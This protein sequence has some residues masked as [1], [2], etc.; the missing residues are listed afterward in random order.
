MT[1]DVSTLSIKVE[2]SNIKSTATLLDKLGDVAEKTEKRVDK[3]TS[4]FDKLSQSFTNGRGS[5]VAY[6][7]ALG[8]S[9]SSLSELSKSITEASKA[10]NLLV[11]EV[12]KVKDVNITLRE[13]NYAAGN[14]WKYH[15]HWMW[16]AMNTLQA[17]TTAF[18]IYQSVNIAKSVI[19]QADAWGQMHARLEAATG[20]SQNATAAQERMFDVSQKLRVPLEDSVRLF[21]RLY[22]AMQKYGKTGEDVTKTVEQLGMGLKLSGATGAEAASV[23]LQLSQSASSGVINGAEFNAVAENGGLIMRALEQYTGKTTAQLKKMGSEGKLSFETLTKSLDAASPKWQ[24]QFDRMPITFEDGMIRIQNAWTYAMGQ[25]GKD[26]EFN[27]EISQ[28]LRVIEKM[29]PAVAKG[30]GEAFIKISKWLDRNKDTLAEI[31]DQIKGVGSDIVGVVEWIAEWGKRI[32]GVTKDFNIFAF[33]LYS[34]RMAVAGIQDGFDAIAGTVLLVGGYITKYILS[35]IVKVAV[36]L[37][38]QVYTGWTSLFSLAAKGADALGMKGVAEGLRS[39]Q[40]GAEGVKSVLDAIKQGAGET[41]DALIDMGKGALT[42]LANASKVQ[43]LLNEGPP[44]AVTQKRGPG[45]FDDVSTGAR[46]PTVDEKALAA[47]KKAQ[48]DWLERLRKISDALA[49]QNELERS[50]LEYGADYQKLTDTQKAR[51]K[52]ERELQDARR[53]GA[54]TTA[55]QLETELIYISLLEKRE[56]DTKLL[57]DQAKDYQSIVDGLDSEADRV[58]KE[59]AEW[60]R[61]AE[62]VKGTKGAVAELTAEFYNQKAAEAMSEGLEEIANKYLR[63]AAAKQ[64][65]SNSQAIIGEAEAIERFNKLLEAS[66]VDKFGESLKDAF[67]AAGKALGGMADALRNYAVRQ[68]QVAK[69]QKELLSIKDPVAYNKAF[70]EMTE[71]Q[72]RGQIESYAE[73]A[74]GAKQFFNERSKEY[75]T[76]EA[77]EKAYRLFELAMSAKTFAQKIGLMTAETSATVANN[78]VK[79]SSN[80][81]TALTGAL[82]AGW[83]TGI[84]AYATVAAMLAAIGVAVSGGGG[85]KS[86]EEM[87]ASQNTGTVLGDSS[88]KSES[89]A[90][91]IDNLSDNSDVALKY[92]ANMLASL[93]NIEQA[94]T[95]VST[96]LYS[97][98][99]SSTAGMTSSSGV[100]S[101]GD[102]FSSGNIANSL[103]SGGLSLL[104]GLFG[105]KTSVKDY[106]IAA[107]SQSLADILENGFQGSTY[108]TTQTKRKVAGITYDKSTSTSTSA[109]DQALEDTLSLVFSDIVNTLTTAGTAL[110][111]GEDTLAAAIDSFTVV[112]DKTSLSGMT[113]DEIQAELTAWIS[114]ISDTLTESVLGVAVSAFQ[115]SGEGLL[116]TAVRVASGVEEAGYELNKLGL[117][118]IDYTEI[119]NKQGDV[120]A[121][122]VRQSI[123]AVETGQGIADIVE[124]LSGTASEIAETYSALVDLQTALT[125]VGLSAQVSSDLLAAAGGLE[126]L[127]DALTS[128]TENF[129]SES[130]QSAMKLSSLQAEFASLGLAMPLTTEAFRALV[131]S[132]DSSGNE[133]L[134]M[135]VILLSDAFAE[136]ASSADSTI[137]D[138]QSTLEEAYSTES[139]A[140]EDLISTFENF[141]DSLA[142]F[143]GD[144]TMGDLSTATTGEKYTTSAATL[145]SLYNK[146]LSGDTEAME[147]YQAAAEEFLSLSREYYSSGAQYTADYMKVL[148]QIDALGAYSVDQVDVNQAQL[149]ALTESVS[150]LI[151]INESVT[152][153]AEAI[154]ALQEAMGLGVNAAV[155]GSHAGGLSNVPFDGY[156]AELHAGERVLTASENKAYQ[157]GVGGNTDALLGELKAL[158]EEVTSLRAEQQRQ[159]QALVASNYDANNQAATKIVE[160]TA[161]ATSKAA[162]KQSSTVSKV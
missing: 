7:Q 85:G 153:V 45:L 46:A 149:D 157:A 73:M 30:L 83:P 77:V 117:A 54:S 65:M 64:S 155:D 22:P 139:A 156:R 37:L 111:Y 140:F 51:I 116:E 60:E 13:S 97:S 31:W 14:S 50:V 70:T 68:E 58:E 121:E 141:A 18:V 78:S 42:S 26:T 33:A 3:L 160:G 20:S 126:A 99:K 87:Q 144:L 162:Y 146:A 11:K 59:A 75:K 86:V 21:Q 48:D 88:A 67:G 145:Q 63:L 98:F 159:T 143:K 142:A 71:A 93:Q 19:T 127:Q 38:D 6:Q 10:L 110:G 94:L 23:M 89:I 57:I 40:T 39:A 114:G 55:S 122:I 2:A 95:G 113:A 134:A 102:L 44:L 17:M 106:G 100:Q 132:L 118:A 104:T 29:I 150:A 154:A 128:Y 107:G 4:A 105:S 25:L 74:A 96:S 69:M 43:K 79:Q 61:K 56:A 125:N 161:D 148:E 9:K 53:I 15:R 120:G 133:D 137:A 81:T 84:A 35:P 91:A 124:V 12:N 28:G 131:E 108:T 41:G 76:M 115:Q 138:L 47:A 8:D 101:I 112:F 80:A 49:A 1:V 123:L 32:L 135:K 151:T 136:L 147:A 5:A 34:V 72:T 27:K 24:E 62:A 103:L 52:V 16:V 129:F 130:E 119:L 82:A 36:A 92:S 152:T 158:R 90:N 109:M 66:K